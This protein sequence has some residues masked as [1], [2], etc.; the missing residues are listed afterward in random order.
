MQTL[1]E[2]IG[3][4]NLE[5]LLDRFYDKVFFDSSISNLFAEDQH[6]MIKKKQF[7]FLS[8]F[9][10][11]PMLYTEEFGHPKMK[12]RHLP[13]A[14]T[15]EAKD[16]WLKCMRLAIDSMSFEDGLGDALYNCFPMVANHMVNR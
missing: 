9:L 10:G 4:K 5:L 16:E 6:E 12:M 15:T 11:G 8:Q 7:M 2:R 14:I 1:Y 3:P 13:H